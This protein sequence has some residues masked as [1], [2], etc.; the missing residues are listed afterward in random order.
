MRPKLSPLALAISTVLAFGAPALDAATA[1]DPAP[2]PAAEAATETAAETQSEAERGGAADAKSLGAITVTARRREETLL[3]VPV[4]VTA[5][6]E[7]ALERLNVTDLSNLQG[8]VP[9]LTIYAARG[10]SSTLT[11]YIRGVGQSDPLWGVDPGVGL[12]IDDVY[13][14]RPQGALLDVLDVDRIEVLRGPQGTLY[15]K[16]TIGGAIK[17]ITKPLLPDPS[18]NVRATIGSYRQA[19]LRVSANLPLGSD[20]VV[21]RIT[22]AS[23]NRDGFGRNLRTDQPVSDKEILVARGTLGFYPS[24]DLSI[25]L[26]ADWMDDQSGVRGAQ[27]LVRTD[28]AL[29][30]AFPPPVPFNRFDPARTLPLA[31][32]YDV[33]NGMPNVN[34]TEMK[35][36]SATVNWRIDDSWYFKYVFGWRRGETATNIDF[37]TLPNII[38]DVAADYRDRQTSHEVNL[39]YDGGGAW[40]GVLG[41]YV[42]DGTAGG[43]VRNNFFNASFGTTNGEV[44]TSSWALYGDWTWRFSEQWSTTLGLRYTDEEKK[45]TVLNRAFSNATFTVPIATLANFVDTV[46]FQNWSPKLSLEYRADPTTLYYG[47]VSRGFKSGGFNIRANTAAVPL[48]ARPFDDEK[49]TS[50]EIGTKR[51]LANDTWFLNAALF[52]NDYRD[53]QLSVFTQFIQPNGQPAFF[54]D[55]TNAGKATIKGAEVEFQGRLGE[56]TTLTGMVAYLNAKY[57]EFIDRG[58]NVADLQKLTNAPKWQSSLTLAHVWDAFGGQLEGRVTGAYQG[59][60]WPTTDLSIDIYQT[61]Y[62]LWNAGLI[63]RADGNPW[64]FALQGSNLTDKAYRTTGYNIPALGILTGFYGPPRQYQLIAAYE[65]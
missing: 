28:N 60:V 3:E 46:D 8:Q 47:L 19:D 17:Y 29:A 32:R 62:T 42:F 54:G 50:W 40:T 33:R 39:N 22:A 56:R 57:D 43:T 15:G 31:S 41:L 65:W 7:P 27:M 51:A 48:S 59:A 23:L 37:D 49:V 1:P 30:P 25:V 6:T 61:G 16:N 9:N 63:W 26:A 53:V 4:S 21:A 45:A 10:S 2:E 34:D 38:A 44:E 5:L 55:F 35:G 11:A 12:Y 36:A 13:V 14:A 58:V 24:E 20:A 18:A 64:T 52:Y